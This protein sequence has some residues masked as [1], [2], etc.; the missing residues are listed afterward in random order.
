[1]LPAIGLNRKPRGSGVSSSSKVNLSLKNSP[2]GSVLRSNL[3]PQPGAPKFDFALDMK[4]L[5]EDV[6]RT[7]LQKHSVINWIK[8]RFVSQAS[9]KYLGDE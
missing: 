6:Q 1:M 7:P 9:Q 3:T 8:K 5:N 2:R 4:N